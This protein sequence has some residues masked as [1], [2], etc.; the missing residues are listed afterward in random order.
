MSNGDEPY[1]MSVISIVRDFTRQFG[2]MQRHVDAEQSATRRYVEELL[3][4]YRKDVY[5]TMT[6][7]QLRHADHE[8][9]HAAERIADM[10]E[11]ASRQTRL[12][13]WLT[14]LT[15]LGT[16]NSVLA[17]VLLALWLVGIAGAR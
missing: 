8:A 1:E 14:V 6:S 3:V 10:K 16:I 7:I 11:R 12:N 2:D 9:A 17:S 4:S 15:V 13:F 5:T